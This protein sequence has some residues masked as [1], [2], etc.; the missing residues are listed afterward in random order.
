MGQ[1]M[2]ENSRNLKVNM[3]MWAQITNFF[4]GFKNLIYHA[5]NDV[6]IM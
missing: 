5:S 3:K 1:Y 2:D 4:Q 6:R